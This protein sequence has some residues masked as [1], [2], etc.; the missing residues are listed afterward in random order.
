MEENRWLMSQPMPTVLLSTLMLGFIEPLLAT[1]YRMLRL[2]ECENRTIDDVSVVICFGNQ[3]LSGALTRLPALKLV[4]CYTTGYDAID[5]AG[6]KARG[7]ATTHAPGATAEAVAEFALALILAH[8]R[9]IV[10][11]DRMIRSNQWKP[12]TL[13]GRSVKGAELGIV[14][15]GAIG[16]ALAE[17]AEA[18]GMVVS[19]WGPRTKDGVRWPY[20]GSLI[21]LATKSDVLAVCAKA[22]ESNRGI[23]DGAVISAVGPTGILV[24]VSRGQLV[25]EDELIAALQAGLVGGAALDVFETEPAPSSRWADVPN[26]L[27]TPHIAGVAKGASERMTAMLME[28]LEC[29]LPV[30]PCPIWCHEVL[31]IS[32]EMR[33]LPPLATAG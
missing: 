18:L 12:Q 25:A 30:D 3:S 11:G 26:V 10:A 21:E 19:W 32:F 20:V 2:W 31:Q 29:F 8:F 4:A 33:G 23:I 1:R 14:G 6:L 7:V 5:V 13:I 27:V 16:T 22:D 24:N 15:L 17:M 9:N 28:N